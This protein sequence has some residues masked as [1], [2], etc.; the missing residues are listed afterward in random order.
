MRPEQLRPV[1]E[2]L[3]VARRTR[4][5]STQGD[6]RRGERLHFAS[7][8]R[9]NRR[10]AVQLLAS[11]LAIDLFE[12]DLAGIA[13]GY[14]GETEKHLDAFFTAAEAAGAVALTDRADAPPG[15]RTD[16]RDAH[17]RFANLDVDTLLQR[18]E[19]YSGIVA[20]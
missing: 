20:L 7:N 13:G 11:E 19:S 15:K 10:L 14:L 12:L 16:V 17:D 3:L 1:L 9:R 6:L 5:E 8:S 2:Q 4:M 18:L